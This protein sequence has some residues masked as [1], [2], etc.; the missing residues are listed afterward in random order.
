MTMCGAKSPASNLLV[1]RG[2]YQCAL[3]SLAENVNADV[4]DHALAQFVDNDSHRIP[5]SVPETH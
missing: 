4:R 5:S 1:V 2:I 3:P